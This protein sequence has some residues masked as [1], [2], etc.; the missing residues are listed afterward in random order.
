MARRSIKL[1]VKRLPIRAVAPRLSA[2]IAASEVGSASG[3]MTLRPVRRARV[4]G[5]AGCRLRSASR[6]KRR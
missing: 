4:K 1:P 3:A 2:S 5:M 6:F